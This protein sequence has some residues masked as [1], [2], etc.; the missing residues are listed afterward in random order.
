[1]IK[2]VNA[3]GIVNTISVVHLNCS[4]KH[5]QGEDQS[6]SENKMIENKMINKEMNAWV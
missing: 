1:M 3:I 6:P 4:H 2:E 5:Y